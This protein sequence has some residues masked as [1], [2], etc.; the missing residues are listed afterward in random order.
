MNIEIET[1]YLPLINDTENHPKEII[2]KVIRRV[3]VR[4]IFNE[5]VAYAVFV[6]ATGA[7]ANVLGA[8]LYN[9]LKKHKKMSY[10]KIN[11]KEVIIDKGELVK[12]IQ[13]QI[14]ILDN[15]RNE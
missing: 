8:W 10:I 2:D 7:T 11:R 1:N 4:G 3:Q 15:D 13:E 9:K 12:V 6:I 14:E 5:P